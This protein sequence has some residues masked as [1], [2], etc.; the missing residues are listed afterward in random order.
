MP[1]ESIGSVTMIIACEGIACEGILMS[2]EAF[3]DRVL[4]CFVAALRGGLRWLRQCLKKK[5]SA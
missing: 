2:R 4:E 3:V 5:I 1:C